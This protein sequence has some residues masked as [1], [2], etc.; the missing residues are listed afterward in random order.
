MSTYLVAFVVG[1][2]VATNPVDVDG[3]PLRVAHVPGKEHLTPFAVDCGGFAL[4]FFTDYYGIAYPG[5]KVDLVAIPDFAFGAMENLGCITF[6]EVALLVDP[7]AATQQ[8]LQRVADVINHELAHM[9]FG[10][11]VTMKWWNGIWLNEAFATFMEMKC[12]DA[13][14]PEW[15]RWV[16]FGLS[17]SSAFETDSLASTRPVEFEVISPDEAEGMFDVLTY[18]KGAAVLRM[19]EQYLGEEPMRDGIRHYLAT[20]AFG[21]TE[22]TDLWDA[23]E[24]VSGQPV[25]RIMDSWIFQGG[26]PMIGLELVG[27]GRTLRLTQERFRFE[28][29][30]ATEHDDHLGTTWA[31][32][33]LLAYGSN[34]ASRIERILLDQPTVDVELDATPDWVLANAG[35]SGF[36]RA[37][38]AGKLLHSLVARADQLTSLERYGLVDDTFASV[39]AGTTTS[40]EF[41]DFARGFGDETDLSVWQRLAGALKTLARLV[42]GDALERYQATVRALA[43]PALLR[44]GWEPTADEDGRRRELRATLVELVGVTG[45]D[46][47]VQAKARDLYR[48]HLADPAA[49]DPALARASLWVV[50]ETGGAAEYETVLARYRTAPTPQ[51]ER[52][53]LFSLARFHDDALFDRTL[54]LSMSEVRS[55]DAPFLLQLALA[56]RTH[57]R[58]AWQFLR[59][60]WEAATSRFPDNTIVRMIEGVTTL[61]DPEVAND[62]EAF[63]AEHSVPQG[64]KTL[65]Q[66]LERLRVNVAL[67]QREGRRLARGLT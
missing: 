62:V 19:L 31:V 32:P 17:R 1:P 26:Y 25:R 8:E 6:R 58:V 41:I 16:D 44:L 50:A 9:W 3:V 49:V 56:N 55:Q 67:R 27:E 12:T 64:H 36:Y 39:L 23:I 35:G 51:E 54:D 21:N 47:H 53:Y 52:R 13:Y 57:G 14:R 46:A 42:D 22:T 29:G 45:D 5:D 34:G 43:G 11:L 65:E 28:G 33:L 2:L 40:T 63:F 66:H 37:R 59:R 60:N 24:S 38:Y 30:T 48:A 18:E 61:T 10:D 7:D 15:Q 4:R 20:H